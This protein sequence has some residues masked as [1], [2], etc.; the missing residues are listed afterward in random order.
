M[1]AAELVIAGVV[2]IAGVVVAVVRWWRGVVDGDPYCFPVE[3]TTAAEWRAAR[4]AL[5]RAHER[6]GPR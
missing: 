5:E 2:L 4:D 6:G 3:G 1:T